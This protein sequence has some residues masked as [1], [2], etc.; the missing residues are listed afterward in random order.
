VAAV[1]ASNSGSPT[2]PGVDSDT[3]QWLASL[4]KRAAE[5]EDDT[6]ASESL[7]KLS[8]LTK[9][10]IQVGSI[11]WHGCEFH[12]WPNLYCVMEIQVSG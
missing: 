3:E 10:N 12:H 5:R 1:A 4:A 11:K 8:Q 9:Q 2:T 7:A 6:D